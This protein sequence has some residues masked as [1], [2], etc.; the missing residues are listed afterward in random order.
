MISLYFDQNI[1]STEIAS[2]ISCSIQTVCNTLQSYQETNNV[3]KREG[4]VILR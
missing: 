4:R 1:L 2:I 3:T